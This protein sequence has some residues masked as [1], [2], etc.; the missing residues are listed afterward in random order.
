MISVLKFVIFPFFFLYDII[1]T[2]FVLSW[3]SGV[4]ISVHQFHIAATLFAL[5][6]D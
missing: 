1:I 5:H 3:S 4:I 6:L 2:L